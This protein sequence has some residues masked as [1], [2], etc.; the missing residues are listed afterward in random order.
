M[1]TGVALKSSRLLL[2]FRSASAPTG[3]TRRFSQMLKSE[4]AQHVADDISALRFELTFL[5]AEAWID[6]RSEKYAPRLLEKLEAK[7]RLVLVFAASGLCAR[8]S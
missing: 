4:D 8:P 3:S 5:V 2:M 1:R 7:E 6:W